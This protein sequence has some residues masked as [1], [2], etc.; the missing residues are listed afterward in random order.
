MP[1]V[2]HRL[3]MVDFELATDRRVETRTLSIQPS[4][5]GGDRFIAPMKNPLREIDRWLFLIEAW[6]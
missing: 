2:D 3:W 6:S 4:M 5:V 1:L